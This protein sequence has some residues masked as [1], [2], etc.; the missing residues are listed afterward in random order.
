MPNHFLESL[1]CYSFTN[2][3]TISNFLG[4]RSPGGSNSYISSWLDHQ[5]NEPI[6][7]PPGLIKA[8]FDNNQ[9]IGKT[10]LITRNNTVP[11]SVM[12]SNMWITFDQNDEIQKDKS[13]APAQWMWTNQCTKKEE[14]IQRLTETTES[15]RKTRDQFL[16]QCIQTV[17][18]EKK[19]DEDK[20]D[21]YIEKEKQTVTEK[22]CSTRGCEAD[23]TFRVCRN[24]NGKLK[25]HTLDPQNK[26]QV[27]INPYKSFEVYRSTPREIYCTTGKPDF[28]NPNSFRSIIQVL[29]N[30]G[31]RAGITKYGGKSREWVFVEC[32]GLPYNTLRD[33]ISN[34]W[35]CTKCTNCFYEI[36]AFKDHKCYILHKVD[37]IREFSWV[38]PVPGLLHVEMNVARSFMKLNWEVFTSVFAYELGFKS[39]KTQAYIRKGSDHHKLW[40]FME[41]IY[42]ALSLELVVTYVKFAM[43][44]K[45]IPSTVEYWEW[46]SDVADAN[47]IYM[48]D[49]TM[50][51]LHSLMLLRSG[52]RKCN[53]VAVKDSIAKLSH[54]IFNRNHP[55]YQNILYHHGLDLCLM[56]CS[57][58]VI[59]E[60]YISGN[61][62][63]KKNKC[64]GGDALLEELNKESKSWLKF[65]WYS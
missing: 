47:Y 27:N 13:C 48:Q 42:V 23:F 17:Y 62:S 19:G 24:C 32:D 16:E 34:V 65:G 40:H 20:I 63:G 51:Y 12:T 37:P 58:K 45:Q 18:Q 29:Q 56:P 31:V 6:K 15:F 25:K 5:A 54:L 35:R 10:Y 2:S 36:S 49:M 1:L 43:S 39:P 11:T 7:C 44:Q 33:I 30:I 4:S 28:I 50:S 52:V 53:A 8:V 38:V 64:Q 22:I 41:I 55:I 21:V 61:K 3:K 46:C 59:L 57:L 9:K 60:Q 14:L 26:Q